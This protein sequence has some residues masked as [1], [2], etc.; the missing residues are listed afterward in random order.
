MTLSLNPT[1]LAPPPSLTLQQSAEKLAV[2]PS[3]SGVDT[4]EKVGVSGAKNRSG[5]TIFVSTQELIEKAGKEVDPV[6]FLSELVTNCFA[7]RKNWFTPSCL[8]KQT[9]V[10]KVNS[11][12]K[13]TRL[14]V[15]VVNNLDFS[16]TEHE[17]SYY[18]DVMKMKSPNY[19]KMSESTL[20]G[21]L[22]IALR[23]RLAVPFRSEHW[24]HPA[25]RHRFEHFGKKLPN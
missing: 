12:Q 7:E 19:E 16:P 2:T 18:S 21:A 10:V 8:D 17:S 6:K 9:P 5:G 20:D 25:S 23:D 3:F 14:D 4:F 22:F 11:N 15:K 24:G 13:W 1:R